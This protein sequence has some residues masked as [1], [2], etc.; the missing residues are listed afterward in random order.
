[1][2]KKDSVDESMVED[3]SDTM[4]LMRTIRDEDDYG[5]QYTQQTQQEIM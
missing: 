2:Y 5:G 4:S 1:M 3:R